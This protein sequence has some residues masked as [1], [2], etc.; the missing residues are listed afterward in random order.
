MV[1]GE[2]AQIVLEPTFGAHR[3]DHD[4]VMAYAEGYELVHYLVFVETLLETGFDGDIV[5]ATSA[6]ED[7]REGV[8]EYLRSC[9]TCVVYATDF[10]CSDNGFT[11]TSNR[12]QD[13]G[14]KMSFQMCRLDYI[15]GVTNPKSGIV[16]AVP[17]P[18]MGRVVATSRYELYWVWA[19]QYNSHSWLML[20][21]ARDAYFQS[22]PFSTL[23]RTLPS[24]TKQDGLLYFFGENTDNTRLGK[25]PKNRKWL[26]R[27]YSL[28]V[29][30][31]LSEKPTICSGST[32]GEQIALEAYLRA[33]VN[34]W[35]ETGVLQKGA[36]Q[37][38]HN[39]LYYSNKLE[40]IKEIRSTTVFDQGK[41]II[42]N[43]GALRE[44]K[45]KDLGIYKE[46][47]RLVYNW[48]GSVSPVVHQ[49][50]RDKEI[51]HYTFNKRFP[52]AIEAW[53][54]KKAELA[55]KGS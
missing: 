11:T 9:A 14:G 19:S 27:G 40:N 54:K 18:R 49:W 36:D 29:M 13:N 28:G 30:K 3:P 45:L 8:E 52:E 55:A 26:E 48:D 53:N 1:E 10:S 22:N 17:D 41:G 21:D 50:D 24:E 16:E 35:D 7:L 51:F 39:Y 23:P 25:S 33:M 43:L 6:L 4:A 15:Y 46:E 37:G 38:F 12:M 47:D 2:D 32:M 42:N 44:L 20:L 31:L 34:E 5:L